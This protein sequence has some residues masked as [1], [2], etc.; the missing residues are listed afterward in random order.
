MVAILGPPRLSSPFRM[1]V[2]EGLWRKESEV[3]LARVR[4]CLRDCWWAIV[5]ARRSELRCIERSSADGGSPKMKN[6]IKQNI[7]RAIDSCPS[8]KPC[9]KESL[10]RVR[11]VSWGSKETYDEVAGPA[12][13]GIG[14]ASCFAMISKAMCYRINIV[15]RVSRKVVEARS[16]T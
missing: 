4:S 10:G 8:R 15:N 5:R 13:C 12:G 1:I 6:L 14:V 7:R 16:E 3:E 2:L 9:V 11:E